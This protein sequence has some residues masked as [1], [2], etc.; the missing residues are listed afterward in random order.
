MQ[1]SGAKQIRR[2]LPLAI[3]AWLIPCAYGQDGRRTAGAGNQATLYV[4]EESVTAFGVN[5]ELS[6]QLASRRTVWLC[7][8]ESKDGIITSKD[9]GVVQVGERDN[10]GRW[11]LGGC[12]KPFSKNEEFSLL[13]GQLA[14]P[15]LKDTSSA[16]ELFSPSGPFVG[17][18]YF[19][20]PVATS[21][22][23]AVE[24]GTD[25]IAIL[26]SRGSQSPAFRGAWTFRCSKTDREFRTTGPYFAQ[27]TD[28]RFAISGCMDHEIGLQ[29]LR[30]S[31]MSGAVA[32]RVHPATAYFAP[33]HVGEQE[34]K[35]VAGFDGVVVYARFLMV[36]SDSAEAKAITIPTALAESM[37]TGGQ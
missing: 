3:T 13:K 29:S 36:P 34:R 6:K 7:A 25:K 20:L 14:T 32:V 1:R 10:D 22:T 9:R 30:M 28:G 17:F 8:V 11:K 12:S 23:G 31:K 33:F 27:S 21:D 18:E 5:G 2:F 16:K 19:Y 15:P 4:R 37:K 26:S 24:T 35:L